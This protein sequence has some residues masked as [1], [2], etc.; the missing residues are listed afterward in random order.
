VAAD[1]YRFQLLTGCRGIEIHGH[2]KHGYPAVKVGDLDGYGGKIVLRDTKNRSD[3][4]LLLSRQA[5]DIAQRNA[6]K[7]KPQEP[8]DGL[9]CAGRIA[10]AAQ[11]VTVIVCAL[12]LTTKKSNEPALEPASAA[13]VM[14]PTCSTL[15]RRCM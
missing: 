3:H 15:L 2:K 8:T 11:G 5:L 14:P 7:R 1:Y 6:A 13:S 9:Q 12:T 4:K 10:S